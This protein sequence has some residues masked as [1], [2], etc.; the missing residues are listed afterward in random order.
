M[1]AWG[2]PKRGN[3]RLSKLVGDIHS[4]P[5]SGKDVKPPSRGDS[6]R[7]GL[8]TAGLYS[9]EEEEDIGMSEDEE[10]L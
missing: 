2:V 5:R 4:V 10:E 9:D 6:R 1:A 8:D 3:S 7:S